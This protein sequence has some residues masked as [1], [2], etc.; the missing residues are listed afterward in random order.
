MKKSHG[1]LW[2]D[3]AGLSLTAE[4]KEILA[5]PFISGVILFS[6]NYESVAQLTAL[7]Q[8][9]KSI[10][11]DLIITVDQEGGRVQRF[12]TG[13]TE[14]PSMAHWGSTYYSAP[15]KTQREF[16][17]MLNIMVQELRNTGVYSSLV[18]VL[19]INYDR[20][21]VIGHRS[22]GDNQKIVTELSAFMIDQFHQLKMPVT[23]KHFPGHGWVTLDSHFHLPVDERSFEVISQHDLQPFAL[24]SKKL[25]AVMLAHVVY[26]N[27]DP[28][29]VCFSR[30][31]IETVLRKQLQFDGIVMCDDLSMQAMA[32]M[33]SYA[34]RAGRALESGCDVLLVCNS[35]EGTID[36]LDGVS[37]RKNDDLARRLHHYSRFLS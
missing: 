24:L 32:Q 26:E 33:G 2:S 3:I 29:P 15:D 9:I 30:F 23:G 16:S 1:F 4:D 6:R 25:D 5:H 37:P 21:Q 28:N 17:A 14:L 13:F 8:Q 19:D 35:R 36:I 22:F 10:S 34:D 27:V 11:T 31:W 20:N 7:T 12:R 18:P